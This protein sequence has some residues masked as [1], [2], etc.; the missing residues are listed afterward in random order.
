M[1]VNVVAANDGAGVLMATSVGAAVETASDCVSS[2][3]GL[4]VGRSRRSK[5]AVMSGRSMKAPKSSSLGLMF[6]SMLDSCGFERRN[7]STGRRHA[8]R[9]CSGQCGQ[10]ST[11]LS[12]SR[13]SFSEIAVVEAVA[14]EAAVRSIGSNGHGANNSKQE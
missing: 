7:Y 8:V 11:A 5:S 1:G 4:S 3:V 9:L 13:R 14:N 2:D 6:G 12:A 10:W